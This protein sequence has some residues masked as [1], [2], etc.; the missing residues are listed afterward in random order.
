MRIGILGGTFDPPHIGHL[1]IADQACAQLRLDHV[2][3]AP[4]GD[5]PHK[6]DQI[7]PVEHRVAMLQ[8]AI[9]DNPRFEL[10]RVDVERPGPHYSFELVEILHA[11]HPGCA[12]HFILG[13]DSFMEM[14]RWRN[15]ERLIAL[16]RLAVA[17]RPGMVIDAGK[18]ERALPGILQRVDWIDTPLIDISSTDL[19]RRV[20]A[21][22]P[23]RYVMPEAVAAHIEHAG[24][25]R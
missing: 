2:W 13:A 8:L 18:V 4:A 20:R 25:Y 10:C 9:Q 11:Q 19:R 5:P 22:W 21:G 16:A 24:L 23:L 1:V 17:K 3:F 7:T 6:G 14:P 15:P 12:W